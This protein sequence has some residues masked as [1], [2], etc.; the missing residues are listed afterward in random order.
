MTERSGSAAKAGDTAQ[1]SRN[2]AKRISE[3]GEK[4]QCKNLLKQEGWRVSKFTAHTLS[5]GAAPS[6]ADLRGLRRSRRP[7]PSLRANTTCFALNHPYTPRAVPDL[8]SL[9][10]QQRLAVET[11]N[12]PVLILAG[13]GMG[14][15]CGHAKPRGV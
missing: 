13:A 15:L 7:L 1:A 2:K 9:N 6:R 14:E 11:L 3:T 12:G 10:P 5:R 4:P 8:R